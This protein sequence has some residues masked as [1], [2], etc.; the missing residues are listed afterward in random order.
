[1]LSWMERCDADFHA[2]P[3]IQATELL[4]Q[5]RTPRDVAIVSSMDR[6]D[7]VGGDHLTS[8]PPTREE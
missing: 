2:E 3:I 6:R 1:M 8:N 4:L 5:E 7:E